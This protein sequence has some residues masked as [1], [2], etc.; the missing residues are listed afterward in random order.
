MSNTYS[1]I[2]SI[3]SM[4]EQKHTR[5]DL[6]QALADLTAMFED[7]HISE[8]QYKNIKSLLEAKLK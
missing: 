1:S 4:L 7:G 3:L 5:G 2:A 8:Y 6:I